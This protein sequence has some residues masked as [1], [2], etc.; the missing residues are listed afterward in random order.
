MVCKIYLFCLLF[1]IVHIFT[2]FALGGLKLSMHVYNIHVEGNVSQI[3][4]LRFT[5]CFMSKNGQLF[6]YFFEYFFLYF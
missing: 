5:F 4:Y 1:L 2:N 3:F 6:I